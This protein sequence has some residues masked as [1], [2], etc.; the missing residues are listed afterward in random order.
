MNIQLGMVCP[1]QVTAV[2]F[3]L[4]AEGEENQDH[5]PLLGGPSISNQAWVGSEEK[6]CEL[7]ERFNY[8]MES[9]SFKYTN[10]S[11]GC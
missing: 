1:D 4:A 7:D 5:L 8:C 3:P 10:Q 2:L 6:R 9:T 11:T